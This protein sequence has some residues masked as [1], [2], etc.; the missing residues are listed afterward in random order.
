MKN[1]RRGVK[2]SG[3]EFKRQQY[4]RLLKGFGGTEN[5]DT[6][7]DFQ[8]RTEKRDITGSDSL[9]GL[10][11]QENEEVSMK[12]KKKKPIKTKKRIFKQAFSQVVN[13]Q[14]IVGVICVAVIGYCVNVV[15]G[16]QGDYAVFK[17]QLSSMSEKYESL[18]D[19]NSQ[20][21]IDSAILLRQIQGDI[22]DLAKKVDILSK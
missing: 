15:L 22:V 4:D 13:F 18:S 14:N 3:A 6:S 19:R 8:A 5:K 1:N 17:S 16:M 12:D 20:K 21:Q 2:Y 10:V 11:D 9:S 7:A